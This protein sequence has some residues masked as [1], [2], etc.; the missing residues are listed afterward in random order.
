MIKIQKNKKYEN[1]NLNLKNINIIIIF[2]DAS[3]KR[4]ETPENK[5]RV[6]KKQPKKSPAKRIIQNK[7]IKSLLRTRFI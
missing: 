2:H 3:Y 6:I 4:A 7:G 5:F 1:L